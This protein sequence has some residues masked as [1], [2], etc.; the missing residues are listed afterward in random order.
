MVL[1]QKELQAAYIGEYWWK[2]WVNTI[3]YYPLHDSLT[4]VVWNYPRQS[5]AATYSNN[6]ATI[7]TQLKRN[8]SRFANNTWNY[9]ISAYVKMTTSPNYCWVFFK[10]DWSYS[11]SLAISSYYTGGNSSSNIGAGVSYYSSW[12]NYKAS[13]GSNWGVYCV[14][15]VKSWTTMTVYVNWAS[16]WT[17][18]APNYPGYSWGSWDGMSIPAWVICA[19]V[20]VESVTRTAQEVADYYNQTKW[21]YWL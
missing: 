15:G 16:I 5:W 1:V 4:D 12:W 10:T 2:P 8:S 9:T 6:M 19:D 18:N 13:V 17:L 7:T 3:L 21:T 11:S 20:L 14:V